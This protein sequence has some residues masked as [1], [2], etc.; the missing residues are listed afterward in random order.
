M[1]IRYHQ[2]DESVRDSVRALETKGH[3]SY[4]RYLFLTRTPIEHFDV[5]LTRLGLS[6]GTMEQY[7]VYFSHVLY[8]LIGRYRLTQYYK[9]YS[10]HKK[11]NKLTFVNTFENDDSARE[12]FCKLIT[13]TE[14]VLFFAPEIVKYYGRNR[15]PTDGNGDPIIDISEKSDWADVLLH[16]KR[17]L[18]DGML[19]NGF[20][21]KNISKH[22]DEMYD[23]TLS[24]LVITHYAKSFMNVRRKGLED[25]IE[26]VNVERNLIEQQLDYVRKNQDM[27]TIGERVSAMA[28]LKGKKEQL[29]DQ[30]K[31]L[32]GAH[33]NASYGQGVVE[34]SHMREMFAD[35]AL[36]T[37][38]RY[39]NMDSRTED[40]V[41]D[42]LSKLVGM[43]AKAA[44]KMI[45][46]DIAM[47]DN[48]KKTISDEMIEVVLPTL[49]RV[50]SEEKLAREK[51]MKAFQNPNGEEN[52]E[53]LGDDE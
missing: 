29:D 41:I 10:Y 3:I 40:N 19:G 5:E 45:S 26:E 51:Y 39:T 21:A 27:F 6:V 38:R 18:I 34:Y 33:S 15:I 28:T 4:I 30:I 49:D 14:T 17:H 44:E 2:L 11:D 42:P 50:E 37:H 22:L 35:V 36:R 25:V 32:Q 7:S 16:D 53:I 31:R 43:M 1:I 46:L 48:T 23:I 9:Q 20:S 52:L 24:P 13:E 8:P 47:Q 12:A